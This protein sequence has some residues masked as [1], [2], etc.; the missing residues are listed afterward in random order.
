[1]KV[2]KY[3][4]SLVPTPSVVGF[5]ATDDA[6]NIL[7]PVHH[8]HAIGVRKFG[9]ANVAVDRR[10][11]RAARRNVKRTKARVHMLNE[12]MAPEIDKI[13]PEFFSRNCSTACPALR[14]I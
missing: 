11:F 7:K 1:M 4:L 6:L 10:L 5:A 14:V 8:K 2:N 12:V 9:E 13:D 3:N